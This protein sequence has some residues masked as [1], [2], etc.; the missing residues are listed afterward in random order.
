MR[1]LTQAAALLC[2]ASL[3]AAD[4]PADLVTQLPDFPSPLKF[5]VYS[6]Y[7]EVPGPVAGYDKLMIHY[8]FDVC[9]N[10]SATDSPVVS[11]HTGGPGGSSLYGEYAEMGYF[12][13]DSEGTYTNDYAWNRLANMLYLESPAGSFLSPTNEKSGFS[14]CEKGGQ[15]Q[16]T[17]HWNDTSQAEAY[18]HTLMAFFKAFP[19]YA[20]RDY[21]LTGESYAGQYV[22]NIANFILTSDVTKS[23]NLK[24]I[25]VGNGCWGGDAT[26]VK[27]NGPNTERNDADFYY[28]K[29]LTS[30]K[31][32]EKAYTACK[33][34]T[35]YTPSIACD[36]AL[37]AIHQEVGPHNVYNVYD[38]CPGAASEEYSGEKMLN[39]KRQLRAGVT[40]EGGYD[41]T[42][43]Q[44]QAVPNY[45][46][47]DDVKA[48][49]HL[50]EV[51]PSEF[52]YTQSGPASVT[53]YPKLSSKIRVLIYNG[54]ADTCVPYNGNE[55]WT[56]G[57]SQAGAI[58]LQKDWHPWVQPGSTIPTGYATSYSSTATPQ[59]DFTFVTV[60]LAGHEVPN[61]RPKASFFMF[62]NFITRKGF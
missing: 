37:A 20:D 48:A 36:A 45:I 2:S 46:L 33:F 32:Y 59:N 52:A 5:K 47:R 40:P 13:V 21:Y 24:G 56:S 31:S 41:W 14:Y 34:D 25:A 54:D 61:Y 11:W 12:Q 16:K 19:E 8:Q 15:I 57:L 9:Q 18:G 60:R 35:K 22:P 30:K 26:S 6:G 39:L 55:E 58:T 28:G 29:G 27:C 4:V 7:L 44:F 1:V 42:C 62:E 53:L 3:A 43:G 49:L 10:E 23:I 38:N 50:K 17:C 51:Y